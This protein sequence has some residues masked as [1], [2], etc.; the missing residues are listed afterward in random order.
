MEGLE[1]NFFD[2]IPAI[3]LWNDSVKTRRPNQKKIEITKKR[4]HNVR[5]KTLVH[6]STSSGSE[7]D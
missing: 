4:E 7:S 5:P 2:P 6:E 1:C 3:I